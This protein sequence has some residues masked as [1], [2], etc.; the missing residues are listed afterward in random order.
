MAGVSEEPV[1]TLTQYL[2]KQREDER[3]AAKLFPGDH[4]T[5]SYPFGYCKQAV[6]ICMTCKPLQDLTDEDSLAGLCYSCSISCHTDHDVRELFNKRHFCCDCGNSKFGGFECTLCPKK[7]AVNIENKYNQNYKNIFC[8]CEQ[9]YNPETEP[10]EMYLCYICEDWFH[11]SCITQLPPP[12]SFKDFVC[13]GCTEKHPF[14]KLYVDDQ[15]VFSNEKHL[16]NLPEKSDENEGEDRPAKK[17]RI[18]ENQTEN[19]EKAVITCK[20]LNKMPTGYKMELFCQEGWKKNLC[21]C[22]SCVLLY[23]QRSLSFLTR[24]QEEEVPAIA[25]PNFYD[26]P[27]EGEE[28]GEEGEDLG[29]EAEERTVQDGEETS[30][31]QGGLKALSNVPQHRVVNAAMAVQS[32]KDALAKFLAPF[33][34]E[35]RVVTKEDIDQFREEFMKEAREGN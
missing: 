17:A 14:L 9:D 33:A 32:F 4:D 12:G 21:T 26:E 35:G 34:Q 3:K 7:D 13:K 11:D 8:Y 28:E 1:L 23:D 29:E 22:D 24:D 30:L 18:E 15:T 10:R 6:Y 20:I 27:E 16:N 19:S 31:Y 2:R 5:C 25:Q